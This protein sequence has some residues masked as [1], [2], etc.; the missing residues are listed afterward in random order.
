MKILIIKPNLTLEIVELEV[1]PPSL[2]LKTIPEGM[3]D[4]YHYSE[5]SLSLWLLCF[6]E[7]D[8]EYHLN[9]YVFDNCDNITATKQFQHDIITKCKNLELTHITKEAM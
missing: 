6:K 5:I 9:A 1:L 7:N 8:T 2:I 4:T 3:A